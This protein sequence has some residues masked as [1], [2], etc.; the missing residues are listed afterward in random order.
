M[1]NEQGDHQ[2]QCEL[3]V[4]HHLSPS[5]SPFATDPTLV[6]PYNADFSMTSTDELD[7]LPML[8]TKACFK[9]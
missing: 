4:Q 5:Q 2:L 6:T 8:S 7:G 1:R 9:L 3:N